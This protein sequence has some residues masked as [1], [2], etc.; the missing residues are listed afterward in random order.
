MKV[1]ERS[2]AHDADVDFKQ[3]LSGSVCLLYETELHS[4]YALDGL[5]ESLGE[6]GVEQQTGSRSLTGL[7]CRFD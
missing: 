4:P 6:Y 1:I 7:V 2:S 5:G 3:A